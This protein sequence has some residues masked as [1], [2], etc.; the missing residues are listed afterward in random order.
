[1]AACP[2]VLSYEKS[3]SYFRSSRPWYRQRQG[4][5]EH[6]FVITVGQLLKDNGYETGMFGKWHLGD[7]DPYRPEDRGFTEV[8]RHGGGGVGQTPDLWDNAYFDGHSF[9]NGEI[10]EAKVFYTDVFFEGGNN[11]IKK[12]GAKKKPFFIFTT[13]NGIATGASVFN[14]GMRGQKGSEYDGGHRV[15]FFH[16]QANDREISQMNPAKRE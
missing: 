9:H 1:L 7:N 13:D 2:P 5:F 4:A 11:F 10:P 6:R 14:A 15:P 16:R 12:T 8:N 3:S